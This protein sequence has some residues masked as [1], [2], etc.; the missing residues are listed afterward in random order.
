[1]S[2]TAEC[3]DVR[4]IALGWLVIAFGCSRGVQRI[5]YSVQKLTVTLKDKDPNMR[6]WAAQSLGNFGPEAETAV[7]DL[8]AALSDETPL[9]RSG[10]AYALAEIGPAAEP[11]RSALL[12]AAKDPEKEVRDAAAYALKR[13]S[14]KSPVKAK[15]G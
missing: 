14:S 3:T 10:A 13:L 5:D 7:P 6:Y 15:K 9:V 4:I 11:A 8:V 1:M 12:G 2:V